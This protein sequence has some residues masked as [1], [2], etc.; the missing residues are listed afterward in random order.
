[1]L[2]PWFHAGVLPVRPGVYEVDLFGDDGP[3]FRKFDGEHWY[4][5]DWTPKRANRSTIKLSMEL[6]FFEW[7][8]LTAE[9][10]Q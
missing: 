3:F 2:T 8:G 7:R 9:G 6:S 4:I 10:K 1:M 5:G